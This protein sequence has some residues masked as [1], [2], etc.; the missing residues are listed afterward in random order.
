MTITHSRR[1]I[2]AATALGIIAVGSSTTAIVM[3]TTWHHGSAA[4][5][6]QAAMPLTPPSTVPAMP[7]TPA[8]PITPAH[9]VT[10][11]TPSTVPSQAVETLQRELG[12]LNYY[13]GP[14]NGLPS[15]QLTAAITYLQRDAHLPQTGVMNAATEQALVGF[16]AHGNNHMGS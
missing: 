4:V 15:S 10:P 5:T 16:L 9:H 8:T 13:E 3:A 1:A 7:I 2:V 6:S 11:V 14:V 12:Q